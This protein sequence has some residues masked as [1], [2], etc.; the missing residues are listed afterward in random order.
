MHA[1][2]FLDFETTGM[3]AGRDGITDIGLVRLSP[4][5]ACEEWQQLVNPGMWIPSQIT[6]LTGISNAMV[7]DSPAFSAVAEALEK[8]LHGALIVAH[9]A[10]FDIGFLA[11]GLERCGR[12]RRLPHVCSVRVARKL[13]PA[14]KSRSLDAL[15]SHFGLRFEGERHRALP[16]AVMLRRLWFAMRDAAG[17]E[18]FDKAVDALTCDGPVETE[19]LFEAPT[20]SLEPWPYAGPVVMRST[21]RESEWHIFHE[22]K[23]LGSVTD[24]RCIPE[25][26]DTG[27]AAPFVHTT[28]RKIVVALATPGVEIRM[29]P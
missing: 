16:D 15:T 17:A 20:P 18:L 14:L 2:A 3:S 28:Y 21:R 29:I 25:I 12:T 11:A 1:L 9:N 7:A 8:R 22:W 26:L 4:G 5:G 13:F 27:R 23:H 19:N 10:K 6:A 24:E